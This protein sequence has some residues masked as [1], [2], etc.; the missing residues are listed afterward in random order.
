[1]MPG[2]SQ[3]VTYDHL[4]PM[5]QCHFINFLM[6]RHRGALTHETQPVMSFTIAFVSQLLAVMI[7]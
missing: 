6:S 2:V 5:A 3:I 4:R 7:G 1:M